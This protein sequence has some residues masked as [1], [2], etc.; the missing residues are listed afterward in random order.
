MVQAAL[1]AVQ[2]HRLLQYVSTGAC[3]TGWFS[4]C[5]APLNLFMFPQGPVAQACSAA[6]Q[7]RSPNKPICLSWGLWYRLCQLHCST[8]GLSLC[9]PQVLVAQA[10][11]AA[12]QHHLTFFICSTGACGTG[13]LSCYASPLDKH[14]TC[15][16]RGLWYRLV[17]LQCSTT[18]LVFV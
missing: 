6:V 1:A 9:F 16:S 5:A 10:C 17:K 3:G 8:T 7:H 12:V 18:R 14:N 13:L 2:H 11:S 4:C 15:L